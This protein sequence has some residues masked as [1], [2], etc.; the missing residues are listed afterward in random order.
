MIFHSFLYVSHGFFHHSARILPAAQP[1]PRTYD[2]QGDRVRD[3]AHCAPNHEGHPGQTW[4]QQPETKLL[5]EM[6]KIYVSQRL[7]LH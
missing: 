3:P 5:K 6:G 1:T 2:V 7:N 4:Q